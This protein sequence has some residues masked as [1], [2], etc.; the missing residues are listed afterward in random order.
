PW[1]LTASFTHPH[2]PYVARRRFWDLYEGSDHLAPEIPAIPY[3]EQDPHSQRLLEASDWR[4]FDITARDIAPARPGYV[5]N[6][7]YLDDQIGE[8]MAAM[9]ATGQ[10]AVI[11][12]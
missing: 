11:V 8:I 7:P 10:E 9:E 5:A 4:A 6:S 12:F 2:D 3:D 1:C